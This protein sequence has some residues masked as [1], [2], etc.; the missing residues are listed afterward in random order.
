MKWSTGDKQRGWEAPP[1]QFSY[2]GWKKVRSGETRTLLATHQ[3]AAT[4]SQ[5]RIS[6]RERRG[7]SFM[8]GVQFQHWRDKIG[9]IRMERSTTTQAELLETS[10]T[11]CQPFSNSPVWSPFS[12]GSMTVN[13][14]FWGK[15]PSQCSLFRAGYKYMLQEWVRKKV[16]SSDS[17]PRG[18][19]EKESLYRHLKRLARKGAECGR[20]RA[21]T[22]CPWGGEQGRIWTL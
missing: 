4:A 8:W 13:S 11:Q 10:V 2:S 15:S 12:K 19:R 3:L 5:R 6:W 9:I 1:A 20:G 16:L 7:R 18:E 22:G 21:N 14:V 17:H